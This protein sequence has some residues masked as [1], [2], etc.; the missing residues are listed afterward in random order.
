MEALFIEENDICSAIVPVNFA[1]AANNGDWISLR[2]HRS[3]VIVLFKGAGTAGDDPVFTLQQA[4]DAAGTGA[5]ALNF[6]RVD[7]KAGTLTG[8]GQWT[9]L[10]QTA[11]NTFNGLAG[12]TGDIGLA[13]KEAIIVVEVRATELDVTNNFCFVQLSVPD[14]GTNSQIGAGLVIL[15]DAAYKGEPNVSA[16]A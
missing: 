10:T 15:R 13:E 1:T 2:N 16:L 11:A 8:V 4:K 9:K 3:A 7:Y 5:K 6:T 14:V 12:A